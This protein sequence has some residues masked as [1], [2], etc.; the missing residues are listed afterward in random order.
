MTTLRI[1][2]APNLILLGLRQADDCII[3]PF[4][5]AIPRM[6]ASTAPCC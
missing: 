2:N 4:I 6:N 3:V 5:T 1:R